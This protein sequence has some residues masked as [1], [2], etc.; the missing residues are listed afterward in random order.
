[1]S[2]GDERERPA[3]EQPAAEQPAADDR[4]DEERVAESRTGEEQPLAGASGAP[5]E[6]IVDADGNVI[7]T[8][9]P[10]ELQDVLAELA[11]DSPRSTVCLIPP[12]KP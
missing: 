12:K 8:D 9:L 6:I 1:M 3:A 5:I 4:P 10:P 2:A 11:P 7:F